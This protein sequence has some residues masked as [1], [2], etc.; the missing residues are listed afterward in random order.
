MNSYYN[1][2][3]FNK[4]SNVFRFKIIEKLSRLIETNQNH[5][6][7]RIGFKISTMMSHQ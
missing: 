4:V 1:Y 5:N 2:S 7:I 6:E 3:K